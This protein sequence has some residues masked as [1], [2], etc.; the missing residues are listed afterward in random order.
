MNTVGGYHLPLQGCYNFRDLGGFI[1]MDGRIVKMDKLFRSD[2]LSTLTEKDLSFLTSIPLLSVVD[3]RSV[4]EMDAAPDRL[5]DSVKGYYK[6]S[7]TPGNLSNLR[8]DIT[9]VNAQQIDDVMKK[10]YR[11]LVSAPDCVKQYHSFFSLIQY[12]ANI[13][14]VFHCTAGKDRTGVAAYLLLTSLGVKEKDIIDDYLASNEYLRGKYA[15]YIA[16]YPFLKSLFGVKIEY[17]EAAMDEIKEKYTSV[18]QFLA[19]VL[20]V[21]I[22]KIRELYLQ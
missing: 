20:S 18:Q 6:L 11:L 16:Q 5:P 2:D 14:L 17:L 9:S 13:P 7:M 8:K 19:D 3:F 10:L 15:A 21:D 22:S 4:S 12:S 1:T